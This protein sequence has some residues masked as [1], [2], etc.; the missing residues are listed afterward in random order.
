M[1]SWLSSFI[2]PVHHTSALLSCRLAE[3][4]A[5]R[6]RS[7]PTRKNRKAEAKPERRP[8]CILQKGSLRS[9]HK[10]ALLQSGPLAI[11]RIQLSKGVS[12]AVYAELECNPPPL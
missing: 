9:G 11:D 6:T 1:I 7:P 2:A 10:W 3:T 8:L 4:R 12:V 5:I